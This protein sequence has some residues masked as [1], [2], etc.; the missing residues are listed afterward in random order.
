[1]RRRAFLAS[2]A[3]VMGAPLAAES[4]PPARPWRLGFLG[5][6]KA[7]PQQNQVEL[8]RGYLRDLGYVD[9][10]DFTI[11]VRWAEG[12]YA[13]L[14]GLAAELIAARIDVFVTP[15]TPA[16][17]A[18]KTA[19]ATVPIVTVNSG[20]AVS[21]GLVAS[22]SRPGGNVTGVT[23]MSP[24]IM[25]K[26]LELLKEAL[27][28][29]RR[30]GILLNPANPAQRLTL[31]SLESAGLSLGVTVY[32]HEPRTVADFDAV[33]SA[34]THEQVDAVVIAIDTL[35]T[36]NGALIG[37][38]ATRHRMASMGGTESVPAGILLGYGVNFSETYRRAAHFVDRLLRGAKAADLPVE[39]PTTFELVVNA[40]TA[41]DLG[42]TIPPSLLLRADRVIQ[43]TEEND[44]R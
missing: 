44:T 22:L 14:P 39:Q 1:M 27:P 17:L 2:M 23:I 33:F 5:S 6:G 8:L 41:R 42:V 36:L 28:R 34:M 15:G 37:R 9:G 43:Q 30:V 13:R 12:T 25:A 4:Q 21:T 11:E 16:T 20:D 18:A 24:E 26:R 3:A 35:F 32:K 7:R 40:R 38:L 19:T 31:R 29:M 10:R